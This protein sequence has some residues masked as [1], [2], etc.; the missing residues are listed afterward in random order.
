MKQLCEDDAS[1]GQ[2]K[3]RIGV[4]FDQVGT[5]T[6]ARDLA[7]ACLDIL[8]K[9][10]VEKQENPVIISPMKELASWYDF[11]TAI[12]ELGGIECKVKPIGQ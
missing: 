11:A 2:R 3:G 4:I 7:K 6:Y 10:N 1:F 5:P 9:G 8:A 12:M